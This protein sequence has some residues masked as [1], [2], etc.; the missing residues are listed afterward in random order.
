MLNGDFP[1]TKHPHR[2][3]RCIG[4]QSLESGGNLGHTLPTSGRPNGWQVRLTAIVYDGH[5]TTD[6]PRAQPGCQFD[7]RFAVPATHVSDLAPMT[8]DRFGDLDLNRAFGV[9]AYDVP[10][11]IRAGTEIVQRKAVIF[12]QRTQKL[13]GDRQFEVELRP[14]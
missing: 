2:E 3:A 9:L 11:W 4:R 6:E 1:P 7:Q 8:T 12:A 5:T 10:A 14:G 13:A